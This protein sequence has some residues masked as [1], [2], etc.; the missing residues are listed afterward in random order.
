MLPPSCCC[1]RRAAIAAA[2]AVLPPS[3]CHRREAAR[4]C[5][6]A[7]CGCGCGCGCRNTCH[8]VA[9]TTKLLPLSPQTPLRHRTTAA[10]PPLLQCCRLCHCNAAATAA[11]MPRCCRAARLR[12][13]F[14]CHRLTATT[15]AVLPLQQRW[16]LWQRCCRHQSAAAKLPL[17][18]PP[19]C[20][21]AACHRCRPRAATKLPPPPTLR[22][23]S[24]RCGCAAT[25]L[26]PPRLCCHQ[27]AAAA[28]KLPTP[29]KLL[30]VGVGVGVAAAMSATLPLSPPS[31][32]CCHL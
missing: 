30:G 7:G 9:A 22:C 19:R 24:R 2:A 1:R 4:P 6:D 32:C 8:A 20:H 28:A 17:P 13:V 31:C 10:L 23:H 25:A 12:R 15:D 3:C 14:C 16:R 5:Q 21:Q 18:P 26:L 29:A 11:V 27:A